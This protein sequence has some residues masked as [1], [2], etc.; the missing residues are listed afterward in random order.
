MNKIKT[1]KLFSSRGGQAVRLPAE[2]RFDGVEVYVWRDEHTGN[3]VLSAQP[4]GRWSDFV[5]LLNQLGPVPDDFLSDR[6]QPSEGS[7][8]LSGTS[9]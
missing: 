9:Q 4:Q 3:V 1:A 5:A 2:F 8:P 7:P 6:Q